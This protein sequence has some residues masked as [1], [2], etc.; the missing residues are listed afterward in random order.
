METGSLSEWLFGIIGVGVIFGSQIIQSV[1][2]RGM[3]NAKND[4]QDLVLDQ[5]ERQLS[6]LEHTDFITVIQHEKIQHDCRTE[7]LGKMRAHDAII[8]EIKNDFKATREDIGEL[9]LMSA[10][11]HTLLTGT[12]NGQ[13]QQ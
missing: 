5:H 13:Q 9:K 6:E 1:K 2:T 11:I 3:M 4:A 10:Q 12:V 8:D 7:L